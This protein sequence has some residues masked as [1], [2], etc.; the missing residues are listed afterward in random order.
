M[1]KITRILLLYKKLMSGEK[2]N[3]SEFCNETHCLHRSFDRDIEDIRNFFCDSF[4]LEELIYDRRENAYY[5][6]KSAG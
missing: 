3:K 1:D 6:C 4:E 5:I 2:V